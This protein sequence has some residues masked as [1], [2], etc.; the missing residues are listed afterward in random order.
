MRDIEMEACT[1][2]VRID[3]GLMDA[4]TEAQLQSWL[5]SDARHR[6]ALLRAQ[7]GLCLI[8]DARDAAS[9]LEAPPHSPARRGLRRNLTRISAVAV[10][11][12]LAMLMFLAPETQE[13]ETS[14]GELRQVSLGDGSIA[15]INTDSMVQVALEPEHRSI[16]L[17]KGE[18]W[19]Q[20]A[21]DRQ[22]PFI[23]SVGPV[24]VQATGTAFSVRR[25]ADAIQVIVTEGSVEAWSED[26]PADRIA[27]AADQEAIVP[28]LSEAAPMARPAKLQALAWREGDI[29]LNGM[30]ALEAAAEFNRYNRRKIIV[31]SPA[32][33]S[34]KLVGYFK[35]HQP[36]VFAQAVAREVGL[37][38]KQIGNDIV[39]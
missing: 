25:K 26:R 19:F 13:Y 39:I 34:L 22:R 33:R 3:E 5:A 31:Q 28:L 10:A 4:A 12:G 8:D 6:G 9:A 1:W 23:V 27:I 14:V 11:A 35:T 18:A 7:A 16:Q 32:A 37:V 2:A 21:K 38:A 24:H 30:T 29:V 36:D 20:V 17:E 15:V